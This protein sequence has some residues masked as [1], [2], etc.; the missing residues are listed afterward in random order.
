MML[1]DKIN[2]ILDVVVIKRRKK[3]G[4]HINILKSAFLSS[5]I[6]IL[7]LLYVFIIQFL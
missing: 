3:S 7:S 5:L 2:E 1:K 4:S 6:E